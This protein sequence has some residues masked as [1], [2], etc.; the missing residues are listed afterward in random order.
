MS[1]DLF[2]LILAESR[3][4]YLSEKRH[5]KPIKQK[6][7]ELEYENRF[8]QAFLSDINSNEGVVNRWNINM[9]ELNDR[10]NNNKCELKYFR[11]R[12]SVVLREFRV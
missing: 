3:I 10:F 11:E 7:D 8:L 4:Q 5:M 2:E 6:I 9:V 1:D 12:Y